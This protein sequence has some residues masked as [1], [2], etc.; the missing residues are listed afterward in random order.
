MVT[1]LH[2]SVHGNRKPF[3]FFTHVIHHPQ[4]LEVV[5]Q[6]WNSTPQLFHSRTALKKFHDKLKLL[7]S[8]LRCLNREAF[9]DIPARVKAAY[10]DL[11]EKQARAMQN[12]LTTTFEEASDAWKH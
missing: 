3:K 10:D 2:T 12:P 6:V 4:F 7:K 9:G 5:A 11:C 8:E 1:H